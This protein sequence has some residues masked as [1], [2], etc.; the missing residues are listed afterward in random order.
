MDL[1][2]GLRSRAGRGAALVVLAAIVGSFYAEAVTAPGL[3]AWTGRA[4]AETRGDVDHLTESPVRFASFSF[5]WGP[6]TSAARESRGVEP[7]AIGV[8]RS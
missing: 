3:A 8:F 7:N 5:G 4:A 6:T 2:R 1:S